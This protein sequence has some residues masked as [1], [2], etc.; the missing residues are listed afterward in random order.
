MSQY[1]KYIAV[2]VKNEMAMP[3]II[4]FP[5]QIKHDTM[6]YFMKK[7]GY[8]KVVSAGMV[9]EFLQ[10]Y[11]ESTSLRCKSKAEDTEYLR[12]QLG[13]NNKRLTFKEC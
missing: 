5:S 4:I 9:D 2:V 11:G 1:N 10:C 6:A 8:R 7:V 3:L 13:I 12:I